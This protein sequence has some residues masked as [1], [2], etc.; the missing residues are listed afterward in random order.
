MADRDERRDMSGHVS[1]QVSGRSVLAADAFRLDGR[2]AVVT[3]AGR[4]LGAAIAVALA[5]S[6]ADLVLC[7]RD[8]QT[9]TID[10]VEATGRTAIAATLDVRDGDAVE[11]WLSPFGVI[12]VVV[13]NAGGTFHGA[14]L[15]AS[16]NAQRALVDENFTSVTNVVRAAVPRM[17]RGGSIVN[18][19]S[20]EAFK[21][22]PGFAVYGAMK[23]AVEHLSRS[24]ALELS[25]LGIR[26]NTVAPDALRTPG[27]DGLLV[28]DDDYGS[29][30]ALGWGEPADIAGAVVFL[31]TSA[32][33]F[34]TGTTVHVDGGSD[35]ARGWRRTPAGWWP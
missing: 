4:G 12:D 29:K 3:G 35:A 21:A 30:L 1:S 9:A 27:D 24:L 15:D 23:A 20:V 33:R 26:V 10:A 7:D 14:F 5:E 19:T 18:I 32:S 16:P 34:V 11:S 17:T 8:D 6:G 28:G 13:N 2:V 22:S 31:A 25:D